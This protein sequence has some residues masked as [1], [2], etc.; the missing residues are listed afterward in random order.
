MAEWDAKAAV[1]QSI[2]DYNTQVD[3]TNMAQASLDAMQY[4]EWD[5]ANAAGNF[6]VTQGASKYVPLADPS[7]VGTVVTIANGMGTVVLSALETYTGGTT[8]APVYGDAGVPA[9]GNMGATSSDPDAGT[10]GTNSNSSP[11]WAC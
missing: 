6:E 2:E 8:S 4:S 3:K 1:T 11:S 10:T 9:M 7:L 5:V